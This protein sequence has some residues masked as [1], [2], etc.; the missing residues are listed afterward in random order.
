MAMN[1][2]AY[3]VAFVH[4]LHPHAM[5]MGDAH[6]II[7]AVEQAVEADPTHIFGSKEADA[8]TMVYLAWKESNFQGAI[9]GDGGL[10]HG[11]WQLHNGGTSDLQ[12]QASAALTLLHRDAEACPDLPLAAYASGNCNAGR[13]TGRS[14]QDAVKR[15][16]AQVKP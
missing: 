10:A 9:V 2:H 4:L 5:D 16:M 1:L 7:D 3:L 11:A 12:R 15:L 8:A 14:R 13:G 6:E